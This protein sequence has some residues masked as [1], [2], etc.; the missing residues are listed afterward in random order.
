MGLGEAKVRS[1]NAKAML[2]RTSPESVRAIRWRYLG[3]LSS[4]LL[5]RGSSGEEEDSVG[6]GAHMLGCARVDLRRSSVCR[7]IADR[8]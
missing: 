5:M 4:G 8:Q 3:L 1:Q 7:R 6:R 2:C